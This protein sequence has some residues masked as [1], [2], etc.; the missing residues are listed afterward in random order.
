MKIT[1]FEGNKGDCLLLRSAEGKN[2]LVD[3]GLVE[4]HFE[5]IFSYTHN[6]APVL[7]RMREAGEAID[8]VYVSHI[9]QDHIGGVLAM[10]NDEFDWRVFDHRIGQGLDVDAPKNPRPPEIKAI[11]HNS[12]HEQLNMN[13]GEIEDALASAAP[14][15]IA[16]GNGPLSHGGDLFSRL[17][18][19][20]YEAAQVSRRIGDGQLG[21]PL[22]PQF[23]GKLV[24]RRESTA[25][26]ELGDLKMTVLGPT[27][28]RLKDLRDKW[29][30]WLRSTKGKKTIRKLQ[31]RAAEDE[32]D[33]VSGDLGA[34]LAF[35]DLG[36]V[37]GDRD[38]VT[39]E[40]V[41]SLTIMVEEEGKKILLTGDARDD[42]IVDDLIETGHADADGHIHVDVLKIQHHGSENNFSSGFGRCV[43]ADH[44]VFCGNGKHENPDIEVVRRVIDSRIGPASRRSPNPEASRSFK[45][46]FT[47]DGTTFK[48]NEHHME[49]V[50]QL[51]ESRAAG[52]DPKMT[53]RFSAKP[54]FSFSV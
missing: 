10:L 53:F 22:N 19:S 49:K 29:N 25:P 46:W 26:I 47:S 30:K 11:W 13:R 44:Y 1:V 36:P 50:I 35:I 43:T 21:I 15:S 51:V 52:S 24:M 48:A 12:F 18:T 20:M 27:P 45:L 38:T 7:G 33:L 37:V 31:R 23:G 16:L 17:A 3:G 8:L 9:D 41:A 28:K 6:V 4:P 32:S 40:N 34:F 14:A 54:S 39:E 2:I 5:R 42:H